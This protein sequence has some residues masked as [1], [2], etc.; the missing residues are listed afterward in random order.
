MVRR[1]G[2]GSCCVHLAG[3][4]GSPGSAHDPECRRRA[5]AC[6]RRGL[7]H[8]QPKTYETPHI[9]WADP[10]AGGA[11]RVL[12][13]SPRHCHRETI[14][15]AQRLSLDFEAI[16]MP[17]KADVFT[18]K[19][20]DRVWGLDPEDTIRE[21]RAKLVK[22]YDVIVLANCHWS[23]FPP[24]FEQMLLDKLENGTGLVLTYQWNVESDS[25]QRMLAQERDASAERYIK[26]AVPVDSV[27]GFLGEDG[28]ASLRDPRPMRPHRQRQTGQTDFSLG[29]RILLRRSAH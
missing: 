24:E 19:N 5:A 8:N 11:V 7:L 3:L 22:K 27:P 16:V 15:L 10:W 17:D 14:E 18:G 20:P 12:V 29:Q 4:R 6:A 23:I 1:N 21:Y 25:L 9:A 13:I 2:T 28:T 26:R